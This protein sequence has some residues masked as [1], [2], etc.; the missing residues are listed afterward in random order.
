M[1][2]NQILITEDDS[3]PISPYL[4]DAIG[5][6]RKHYPYADYRLYRHED[7]RSFIESAYG[8]TMLKA[9]DKLRPYAYKADLA[10][11]LLLYEFGGWYFDI[12]TRLMSHVAISDEVDLVAFIDPPQYTGTSFACSQG[13]VYSSAKNQLFGDLIDRVLANIKNEY[14]GF[15]SLCPTGPILFGQSIA[16]LGPNKRNVFGT[17]ME[18]T[19]GFQNRNRAHVF[20]DGTI[21]ALHKPG[22]LGGDLTR[23]GVVGA[24]NYG[25]LYS[26]GQVYDP[27]ITF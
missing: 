23:L 13:V 8:S 25:E 4:L 26:Q 12:S 10:R 2:I 20:H 21:F 19:P 3:L 27:N 5:T 17:F 14:Y 15:N 16:M 1:K 11:Y 7:L 22:N 18:L 9:F 24:N 6:V